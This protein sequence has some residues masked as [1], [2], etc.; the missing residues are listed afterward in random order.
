LELQPD[1]NVR[2]AP[3]VDE[4]DDDDDYD[5]EGEEVSPGAKVASDDFQTNDEQDNQI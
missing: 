3:S 5:D 4:N 2:A 1:T